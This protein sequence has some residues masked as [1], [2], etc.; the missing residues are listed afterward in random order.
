ML[1]RVQI[2]KSALSNNLLLENSPA[3][4]TLYESFEQTGRRFIPVISYS[5]KQLIIM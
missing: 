3:F 5:A 4:R 2:Q 1:S